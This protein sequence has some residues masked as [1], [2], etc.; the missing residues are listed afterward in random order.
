MKRIRTARE[1]YC[2]ILKSFYFGTYQKDDRFMT[3]QEAQ[4]TY[5]LSKD[6]ICRVY[7]MLRNDGFIRTDGSNGTIVAFD[8]NDPVHVAKVPIEW[9]RAVPED[10]IPYEVA[11]KLH[12]HSLYTGLI[13]SSETQLQACK[14][15]VSDIFQRV[16]NGTAYYEE[17]FSFWTCAISALDNELL[18]S[19]TDHFIS[20]YLYLLPPS[21]IPASQRS[22]IRDSA[23]EYYAFVLDAIDCREFEEFPNRFDRQ[24]S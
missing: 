24:L 11:M 20:R 14:E 8:L 15:I 17:V 5:K 1:L 3:Y 6:T 4:E 13:H 16:K 23:L 22:L 2:E 7:A 9:P 10:T 12:A 19:I 18:S 21:R